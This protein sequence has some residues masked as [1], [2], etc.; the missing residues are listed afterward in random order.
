[1]GPAVLRG[2]VASKVI[3]QL[4][5]MTNWG[6]LDYLIIDFPPGTSDIQLSLCQN[7]SLTGSILVT[8]PHNLSLIDASKGVAM[9]TELGVPT[10]AMVRPNSSHLFCSSFL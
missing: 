9:F 8:T 1:M 7:I 3:N 4:A 2:P 10:L 6:E 5:L